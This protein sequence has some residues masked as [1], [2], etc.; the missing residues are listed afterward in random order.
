M[1]GAKRESRR[2][3][4]AR[5][6]DG[7]GFSDHITCHRAAGKQRTAHH[8]KV[9]ESKWNGAETTIKSQKYYKKYENAVDVREVTGSSPVSSTR[10]RPGAVATGRFF[11]PAA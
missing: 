6:V 8:Q 7:L 4:V 3:F 9:L 11:V 10:K 2:P 1:G 5:A